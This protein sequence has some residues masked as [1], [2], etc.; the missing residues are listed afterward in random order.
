MALFNQLPLNLEC[1]RCGREAKMTVDLY[2][3]FRDQLC[4]KLG[5]KCKWTKSPLVKNGGRPADGNLDGKGYT[6]CPLCKKDFFVVVKVRKDVFMGVEADP[7]KKP[8]IPD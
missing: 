1:P 3:G 5:D 2:F 8:L 6:E 4:Y 7:L